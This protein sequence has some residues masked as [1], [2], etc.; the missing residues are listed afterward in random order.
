MNRYARTT[1]ALALAAFAAAPASAFAP[2]PPQTIQAAT[3]VLNDLTVIPGN[4]IPAALLAQAQGVAIIPHVFKAGFVIG[5]RGGHGLIATR[6]RTGAWTGVTF[7]DLG[8]ASFG[9]QAGVESTD[10]VLVFKTRDSLNRILGGRGKL[11]LGADAAVAAGPIGR[12]AEAAT[13]ALL[14]AE[15]VSYSRSRGL[16][17]GVAL[18]GA[19]IVYNRRTN[20]EY[21]NDHRAETVQLT[22]GL[23]TRLAQ[24]SAPPPPAPAVI[25]Q[26]PTF[27]PGAVPVL[28][29]APVPVP[30][31]PPPPTAP[32][33]LPGRP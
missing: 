30:L 7:V 17:A 23:L 18:D 32:P 31:P 20:A 9:L 4:R 2:P 19:A 1:L 28:P 15:I 12:D 33:G 27:V 21:L 14:R 25:L 13:D 22:F 6:D 24:L 16:F 8:G 11:T 3:D 29:P 5:G 10:V 26:P